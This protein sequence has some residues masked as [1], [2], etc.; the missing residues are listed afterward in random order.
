MKRKSIFLILSLLLTLTASAQ[1]LTVES[2]AL[3]GNDISASQYER[4]D[5]IKQPCALV[6]VQLAAMGA[7]FEGN[8]IQ[9][10]EYKTGEYWVYMSGGSKELH[11]KHPNF[12][13]L[14]INFTDY[15]I[16]GLEPKTT[17]VLTLSIPMAAAQNLDDGMRYLAMTVEPSNATVYIDNNLQMLQNGSLSILLPI[18]EH[19]YRVEAQAHETKSGTFIIGNETLP[20]DIK[21][22]S[23]MASLSI[24]STTHG[25][26][27]YVN[28]QLRGTSSWSGSLM[29]GTYRVEGRLQGYR[30]HRQIIT[31]A[32]RDHQQLT[33][34]ALQT[35]TGI[36]DVNFQPLKAEVW[37]DGS[38]AGISP[39][40][41][42]NMMVGNHVVEI[43]ADGYYNKKAQVTIEEGKTTALTGTLEKEIIATNGGNTNSSASSSNNH[44][45]S[46]DLSVVRFKL[47]ETDL[48]ARTRETERRDQNGERA[49]LI[50][51]VSPEKGFTFDGG[52]LGI[53]C[54]TEQKDSELWL[55]V[56]N[57][58]QK[59][60][61]RHPV[62][63]KLNDYY[64]PVPIQSG[65]TYEM[66][67]D[68]GTG[69]FATFTT[70]LARSQVC[71]DGENL[72]LSPIYDKYLNFGSHIVSATNGVF[73]GIDT[74][75]IMPNDDRKS[76][77]F[78]VKMHN[79]SYLFGDVKISVDNNADIY[80]E[81]RKVGTGVWQ[82]QLREGTYTIET[83][84]EN[85]DPVVSPFQVVRKT[86]N[87]IKA[88]PPKPQVGYLKITF[89]NKVQALLDGIT[90]LNSGEKITLPVGIHEVF[91][92]GRGIKKMTKVYD[93]Q[94][95]ETREDTIER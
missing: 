84:K 1:K 31:L 51:I 93:I 6:K 16:R 87:E 68:I 59:L 39:N 94:K 47:L 8:V 58:A 24:S 92:K 88:A 56:P 76:R 67:L 57:R 70:D 22:E 27:I 21:L 85:C 33:I 43:R 69:R 35:I 25:T 9:P 82:T 28:D 3:A 61:I 86:M 75:Y 81:G 26:Q 29:P 89:P 2:M 48:T 34:P 15:G 14:V 78:H 95:D 7:Q 55:Y 11:V 12:V 32:Q 40:V 63:G 91:F 17:Y 18:G 90:L 54:T 49:A 73:G 52:A 53:V 13:P 10:V 45:S 20:L 74:I 79:I 44:S 42:R 41:F 77:V 5:L 83:R 62:F 23:A 46:G 37:I 64:Y 72:G 71:L 38:K 30:N 36:L 50:K 66:L 4:K 19:Q 65:R 60:T 80:F